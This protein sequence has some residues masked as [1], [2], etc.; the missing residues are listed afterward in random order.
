MNF[1]ALI[2]RYLI[3]FYFS[4]Q[5]PYHYF[6]RKKSCELSKWH[7][8][9]LKIPAIFMFAVNLA[10]CVATISLINIF[11]YQVGSLNVSVNVFL[12]CELTKIFAI[13]HR[14]F[15]YNDLE[16]EILR[17]FQAIEL[18][19]RSSLHR[20]ISF[21]R[22]KRSFTKKLCL[23][24]GSF[25]LLLIFISVKHIIHGKMT[26]PNVMLEVVRFISIIV[27]THALLFIDLVAFFLK[28]LNAIIAEEISDGSAVNEHVFV[29]KEVRT[30]DVIRMQLD[31]HKAIYF[32]VWRIAEQLNEYFGWSLLT[33]MMLFFIDF[34]ISV[35]WQLKVSNDPTK[36]MRLA[37]KNQYFELLIN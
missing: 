25:I 10:L 9:T 8:F 36:F 30:S 17:N 28:H 33:L 15:T 3:F 20:P 12:V 1:I 24:F 31:K 26:L 4:G 23:A 29:V 5:T 19:F 13:L 2:R 34:V 32:R 37:R 27:C 35:I 11:P 18:L 7:R 14:N 6:L 16:G 21:T 22:F